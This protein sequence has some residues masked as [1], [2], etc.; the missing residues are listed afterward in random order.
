MT[1]ALAAGLLR[2]FSMQRC[3]LNLQEGLEMWCFANLPDCG[4][5]C[6]FIRA[7]RAHTL[8][9]RAWEMSEQDI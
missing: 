8:Q 3:A 4:T 2:A 9:N 1:Q 5:L 6:P 7:P